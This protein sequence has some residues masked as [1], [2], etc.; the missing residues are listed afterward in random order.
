[1]LSTFGR[2]SVVSITNVGNKNSEDATEAQSQ[3]EVQESR[4][5]DRGVRENRLN[6]ERDEIQ[7]KMAES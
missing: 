7:L 4:S 1:L 6:G 3:A 5:G 2:F